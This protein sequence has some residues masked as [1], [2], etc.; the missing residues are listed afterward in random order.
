MSKLFKC[1]SSRE[2]A[3]RTHSLASPLDQALGLQHGITARFELNNVNGIRLQE[4]SGLID[5]GKLQVIVEKELPLIEARAAS[6][7]KRDQPRLG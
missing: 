7:I 3:K 4:I 5:T 6:R 1:C 2:W